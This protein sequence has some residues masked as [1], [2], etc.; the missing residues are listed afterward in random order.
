MLSFFG[1]KGKQCTHKSWTFLK[2]DFWSFC[3]FKALI[4][5]AAVHACLLQIAA[6]INWKSVT[7]LHTF[8][9]DAQAPVFPCSL[10]LLW[11]VSPVSDSLTSV[12][13]GF[14]LRFYLLLATTVICH[15]CRQD[16]IFICSSLPQYIYLLPWRSLQI[17]RTAANSCFVFVFF[18]FTVTSSI[19]L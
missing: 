5:S 12:A 3:P 19:D 9:D 2:S 10:V 15:L 1:F 7:H 16:N 18:I 8:T 14:P 11:S 4:A 13:I 17:Q 6:P